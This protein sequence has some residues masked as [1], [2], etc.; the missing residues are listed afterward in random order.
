MNETGTPPINPYPPQPT[1]PRRTGTG[2]KI[3]AVLVT[4][5]L[6]V[7]LFANLLL[8]VL[9]GAVASG[10]V[11]PR[12]QLKEIVVGGDDTA[13]DKIVIIDVVGV[14]S[15]M[16][17]SEAM[18]GQVRTRLKQAL[19]DP[20]VKAIILKIDSPGG[21]VTAS[22]TLYHELKKAR[23]QKPIIAFINS[24]GASGAY[25]LSMGATEVMCTETGM[26]GSIGVIAQSVNFGALMNKHG[27]EAYTF[28]SGKNKD[29]L[30][31]FRV[32]TEKEKADQGAVMQAMIDE[33][34]E[35][36]LG[37]VADERKLDKETLRDGV[38]DGRVM[39]GLKAK[40]AK[41]V[42]S[43]G[44]I[45]DAIATAKKHGLIVGP[46]KQIKY[47][48]PFSLGDIF[49]MM[50]SK[51]SAPAIQVNLL[52]TNFALEPG[53]LYFLSHHLGF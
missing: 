36:F 22:D 47:Q 48:E 25:Y 44:T 3:Y 20:K 26:T 21:E 32:P 30:N 31:P 9:V 42:D 8:L 23:D 33:M 24:V 39:T 10:D 40:D 51:A 2:M 45:E 46:F 29:L 35:R 28:K 49:W 27:V 50:E 43:V 13:S 1:P 18:V 4:I 41:L 38:A 16:G 19:S 34:Y 53:R 14:I 5:F 6:A 52:P 15:G 11:N 12:K 37:I 17:R 7:S